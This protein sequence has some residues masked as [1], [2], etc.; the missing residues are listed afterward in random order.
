V[1]NSALVDLG[2]TLRAIG[3]D[4]DATETYRSAL[5]LAEQTGERYERA[6]ALS[7]LGRLSSA[8]G[9]R[10]GAR[11]AWQAAASFY[12]ALGVPEAAEIHELLAAL[13]Q[14]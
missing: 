13:D 10:G 2:E 11:R 3:E 9:D 8:A 12:D 4:D 5:A 14:G 1:E 7:G 6:R